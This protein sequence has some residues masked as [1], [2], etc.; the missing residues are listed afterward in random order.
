LPFYADPFG[1]PTI[2][3]VV[4]KERKFQAEKEIQAELNTS[5]I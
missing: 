2:A 1:V 4:Y 3:R 5:D